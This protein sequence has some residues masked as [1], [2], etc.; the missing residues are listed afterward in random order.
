MVLGDGG[1]G[2]SL[3]TEAEDGRKKVI[4]KYLDWTE[5]FTKG[6]LVSAFMLVAD[7]NV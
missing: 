2:R 4:P 6:G 7:S 3:K 1:R 5:T